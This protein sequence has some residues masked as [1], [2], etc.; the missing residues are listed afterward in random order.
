MHEQQLIGATLASVHAA[1]GP[2]LHSGPFMTEWLS[3]ADDVL[4]VATWLPPALAEIRGEYAALPDLT[5]TQLHTDPTPEAFIHDDNTGVTGLIDWA[6]SCRGPALYDV[7]SAVMYL[8]GPDDSER[9]LATY[10]AHGP[11][12]EPELT[13]LD[14]F[15][16]LRWA[17]QASYY[18][19]RIVADDQTG[20]R[21]DPEHNRDSV[22]RARRGIDEV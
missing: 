8:G 2:A 15:R 19:G 1:G 11:L 14:S 6:G 10:A 21:D 3:P 16:R 13:H 17:I 20:I 4:A 5:W 7:A 12:D 9:F 18:A 22:A